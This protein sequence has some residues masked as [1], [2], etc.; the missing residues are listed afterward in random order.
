M[1]FEKSAGA[2]VFHRQPNEKIEYLLLEHRAGHWAFPKGL[3]ER[4]ESPEET[5]KREIEEETGITK[6]SLIPG[7]KETQK[8]FF[9]V[10]YDYQLERG[11]KKGESVFKI[12]T[13]FLVEA[14]NQKVKISEE[15]IGY[16]WLLYKEALEQLT[17]KNAKEILRKANEFLMK[18]I[19]LKLKQV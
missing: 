6:I 1:P 18:R 15:H 3:I 5:A 13:F 12:V 10:K 8:Y 4:N 17:F 19:D 9:K 11:W 2:V 16:K 7:F 14:K